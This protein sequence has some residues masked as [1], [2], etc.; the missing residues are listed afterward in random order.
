MD[1]TRKPQKKS[2]DPLKPEAL[3]REL[4][5]HAVLL[6]VALGSGL[7]YIGIMLMLG[8]EL[9]LMTLLSIALYP[10]RG[11]RAHLGSLVRFVLMLAFLGVF[12]VVTWSA[13]ME[14]VPGFERGETP[15]HGVRIE[16]AVLWWTLGYTAVHM[17]GLLLYSR[18]RPS[19]TLAWS[20]SALMQGSVTL[21]T[22]FAMIPVVLLIGTPLLYLLQPWVALTLAGAEALLV[23]LLVIVR[24]AVALALSRMPQ[25]ALGEIAAN[26]YVD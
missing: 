12:V 5:A 25:S 17:L 21:F 22:V 18:T 13:A 2:W 14:L 24:C 6:A 1:S 10:A 11:V 9:L 7:G 3:W 4:I 19:P 8:G 15:F 20:E 23:V 26:P 16:V